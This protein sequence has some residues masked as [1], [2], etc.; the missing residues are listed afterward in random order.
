M[1]YLTFF[2]H[3]MA[4][5]TLAGSLA[6]VAFTAGYYEWWAIIAAAVVGYVLSLPLSW[7]IAKQLRYG[8]PGIN[9]KREQRAAK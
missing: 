9:G 6:L 8:N 1:K 2:V 5:A 4:G 3:V 7:F